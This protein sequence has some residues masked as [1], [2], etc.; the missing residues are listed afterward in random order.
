[1]TGEQAIS[2][3]FQIVR[4]LWFQQE[5]EGRDMTQHA[6]KLGVC[7]YPE[8]WPEAVW[9]EDAARMRDMGISVVRVGEFA[10][11][12]LEPE[13][14]VL[15]FDWLERALD[16]L[17]Q[18]GLAVCLGTPTATPPKWLIDKYPE[19]LAVGPDGHPRRF[20][21][22]RHYSFSSEIYRREACR[23]TEAVAEQFGA[24]EAVRYWQTDNEYGCHDTVRSY[25]VS[26]EAAFRTWLTERYQ[27]IAALNAAWGT[28]F[29]SQE[30]RSF[31]EI[32]LPN[33]TVTE[34]NPSH[35]LDFYR[36]SSDQVVRFNRAQVE[37]IRA[38]SPARP[39]THNY[40]GFY[41]E[42]DHFR[43][44]DDLDLA[45]WDSYPLGFLDQG[46]DPEDVKARYMRQGHPD[47][48]AFHHDLYRAVGKGRVWVMEQQPGP[49]NWAP[50]NP[51]P[52]AGMVEAWSLEAFG[53]GADMV[54]Y[55]RWRQA[56]FAQEQMHA[57]LLCA[58]GSEAAAAPEVRAAAAKIAGAATSPQTAPAALVFSYEALWMFDV[59]PQGAS[60]SYW[61]L[62]MDW[63][64]ALRR[65][66]LS[67]DIVEPGADL[68]AY[69]AV[70]IP[71]LPHVSKAAL[72]AFKDTQ[73]HL[74]FGPRSG[75][76]TDTMQ[77]PDGLA[78][79]PLADL[80]PVRIPRVESFAARYQ[81]TAEWDGAS[82]SGSRWL[83]HVE[84]LD[85]LIAAETGEGL[86]YQSG[87]TSYLAT[88][89]DR[90]FLM[91][92]IRQIAAVSGLTL[93]QMPSGVRVR[94]HGS[95]DMAVNY[96]PDAVTLTAGPGGALTL[97]AGSAVL[98]SE[99][100]VQLT[101]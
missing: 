32:D 83:D 28:V 81:I 4:C 82:V 58:D 85:P 77:I 27:D 96:A 46:W 63:Y 95:L 94:S 97:G 89:P 68:N 51:A 7:Y 41:G 47:F 48:A 2:L 31:A 93:S 49:V 8:H 84:G 74:V 42:F 101:P 64:G 59:Q 56:P 98:S 15:A 12:R 73:A 3:V 40:M 14:G 24:H 57:G 26:A 44:G 78:P 1:M 34:P 71:S 19:I 50:H 90:A 79:G 52:L 92:L 55:F 33:L 62:V 22:R 80:I 99:R 61:G 69:K 9:A 87:R 67:L 16:T 45:S 36:F 20:G 30:Y 54:S 25:C 5:D 39:I 72:T 65:A 66:G 75:S 60:W 35:V 70:F 17:G 100:Q 6:L 13:P 21:S 29:W 37:I 91:Q 11:S 23:I 76:K 88:V 38:H 86:L 43:V 18:A 53:H 10:W